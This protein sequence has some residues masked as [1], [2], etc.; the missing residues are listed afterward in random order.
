MTKVQDVT[1]HDVMEYIREQR[2]DVTPMEL[3]KYVYYAQ[4]WHVTWEGER[5]YPERIEAWK[6]GPVCRTAWSADR[7]GPRPAVKPL[8]DH[9]REVVDA[10]LSFYGRLTATQLR[11]LTHNEAPWVQARCGLPDDANSDREI[12]VAEM[13]RF[14]TRKSLLGEDIPKRPLINEELPL[15]D[16]LRI[17]DQQIERWR[18]ALDKLAAR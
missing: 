1:V 10:V 5:L 2:P 4:A 3:Q 13:R 11:A 9:A 14:Y 8:P 18:E 16:T 6:H 12:P 17:P 7:Y 15:H